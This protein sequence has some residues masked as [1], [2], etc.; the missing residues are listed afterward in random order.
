MVGERIIFPAAAAYLE[1]KF[2][3]IKEILL[4]YQNYN[5]PWDW[6]NEETY[7]RNELVGTPLTPA[8]CAMATKHLKGN[9]V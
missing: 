5:Y 1:I 9:S 7:S 2:E 8:V 3:L 6:F 4:D